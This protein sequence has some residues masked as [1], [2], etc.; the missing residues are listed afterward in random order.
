MKLCVKISTY[1]NK[2]S[3]NQLNHTKKVKSHRKRIA[4]LMSVDVHSL[5]LA[6]RPKTY[7]SDCVDL[8]ITLLD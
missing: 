3:I 5:R 4:T 6:V 7:K 2:V 8:A 1:Y